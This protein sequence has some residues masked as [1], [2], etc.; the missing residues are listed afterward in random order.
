[1]IKNYRGLMN[2]AEGEYVNNDK[3]GLEEEEEKDE[4]GEEEE[5]EEGDL[6]EEKAGEQNEEQDE[7][8]DVGGEEQENGGGRTTIAV[9]EAVSYTA[10]NDETGSQDKGQVRC[11]KS[12]MGGPWRDGVQ[13]VEDNPDQ[14]NRRKHNFKTKSGL[15]VGYEPSARRVFD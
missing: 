6:Q 3:G 8:S 9:L 2:E 11:S 5:K 13:L 7:E 15:V 1:M 4:E 14:G 12:F 10:K